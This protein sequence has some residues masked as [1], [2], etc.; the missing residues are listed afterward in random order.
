MT[1]NRKV[2]GKNVEIAIAEPFCF[3]LSAPKTISGAHQR[4]EPRTF[5]KPR[6]VKWSAKAL[7]K[8]MQTDAAE[9]FAAKFSSPEE[10]EGGAPTFRSAA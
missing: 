9:A 10:D 2:S 1:S 6:T 8:W 4:G 5:A 3:L 7:W